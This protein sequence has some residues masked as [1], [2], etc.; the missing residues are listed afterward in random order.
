MYDYKA[1]C[2]GNHGSNSN[3]GLCRKVVAMIIVRI[4]MQV[5]AEKHK[6]VLQTL[7]SLMAPMEREEGCLGY[8]FLSD[9]K[10]KTTFYVLQEWENRQKL[11]HHLKSDLFGVL[12][13]LKS[14]LRQPHGIDIYTVEKA[15][16]MNV[17]LSARNKRDD[18]LWLTNRG[19]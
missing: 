15:E 10:D 2:I 4:S 3:I 13:G 5:R 7:L 11:D 19:D 8:M 17:I 18:R 12:L 14:L 6:E 9:I 16:G 1:D